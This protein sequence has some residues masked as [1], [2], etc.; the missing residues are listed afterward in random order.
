MPTAMAMGRYFFRL[1]A[2]GFGGPVA[3][4]NRMRRDLV[5]ERR[6]L[7]PEEFEDGLALAAACPGPLAYQLGVYC[8]YIRNGAAG[9]L[10]VAVA[11]AL[12]PFLL[13]SAVAAAYVGFSA[14]WQ[15][16]ALFYGIAPVVVVLIVRAC[17]N[18]ARKTLRREP[19]PW[20]FSLVALAVTVILQREIAVLF[21]L[22]GV[23][24]AFLFAV[25][26][27]IPAA[28][29]GGDGGAAM[30][31]LPVVAG[32]AASR[33]FLFFFKTGLLVFGSGL[34]IV[35]FLKTEVV[36]HYHWLTNRQFLDS[37]AIGMISPGPVV[38]TA[39]FVGFVV[40]GVT[41]ALAATAGIFAP[42]VLF[43]LCATPLLLRYRHSARLRGFIRGIGTAVVGVLAGTTFLIART[44]IGDALTIALALVAF[45]VLHRWPRFPEPAVIG[46]AGVVGLVAY[47]LMRR[48]WVLR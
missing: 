7:T 17:W 8:G 35:P 21:V 47:T 36:D 13:V 16:R 29:H 5:E 43:V 38:I 40:G 26:E 27:R 3:L 2:L 19:V 37:V 1:G 32:G 41:G 31:A 6:W 48:E 22:A 30:I 15:L 9:G 18:L 11:F 46:A 25:E 14:A 39:T 10:V 24:G 23:L 34:V 44:A 28:G 45:A 33:L 20:T 42:S 4:A 12:A